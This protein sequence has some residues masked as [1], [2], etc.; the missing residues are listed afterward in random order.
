[1]IAPAVARK[2]N[3][4]LMYLLAFNILRSIFVEQACEEIDGAEE[5]V[6]E[7]EQEVDVVVIFVAVEAVSEIVSWVDGG[8]HFAAVGAEEAEVAIAHFRRQPFAS[9]TGDSKRHGQIVD[10]C[11]FDVRDRVR[12]YCFSFM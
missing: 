5:V 8:A 4:I 12:S 9:Q 6:I 3:I 10:R 7:S 11:G 2:N 1:M